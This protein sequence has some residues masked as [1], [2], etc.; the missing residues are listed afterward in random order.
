MIPWK[1][2]QLKTTKDVKSEILKILQG[3]TAMR[4]PSPPLMKVAMAKKITFPH[5]HWIWNA[6]L[7][8]ESIL[9]M[10]LSFPTYFHSPWNQKQVSFCLSMKKKSMHQ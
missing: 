8:K 9:S 7:S 1:V 3:K 2:I 4:H 6:V 10:Q 5:R